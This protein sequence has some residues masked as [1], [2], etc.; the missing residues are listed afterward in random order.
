VLDAT[1]S[2]K[3][4]IDYL[5]FGE[6]IATP[7]GGRAAPYTAGLYPSN[8][9]IEAQKFTGKERD[10][11]AGLDHSWFRYSSAAQGRWSSADPFGGQISDPQMLNRYAYVRNNPLGF[12]DPLGLRLVCETQGRS[13]QPVCY[14][15][16]QPYIEPLPAGQTPDQAGSTQ[17]FAPTLVPRSNDVPLNDTAQQ[18]FSQTGGNLRQFWP[19]M[20]TFAGGAALAGAASVPAVGSAISSGAR[21]ALDRVA[22]GPAAGR[23]FWSGAG[24][25]MAGR[26]GALG[27]GGSTLEMTR[28]GRVLDFFT[29]AALGNGV[30]W[31]RVRPFWVAT[32]G[33]FA[34]GAQGS[35][36]FYQG[37][38][39]SPSGIWMTQELP[40]LVNSGILVVPITR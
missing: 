8:P 40:I 16:G 39:V 35:V 12:V 13:D 19:F 4:R 32:S 27:F 25:Q 15:N 22:F 26:L 6:E 21:F 10:A 9:D 37:L 33:A 5:P 18:V 24:A 29:Q 17:T 14:D 31:D 38:S 34:S 20:A 7:V 11:E 36:L 3:E 1:G 30:S 28:L 23:V 2:V